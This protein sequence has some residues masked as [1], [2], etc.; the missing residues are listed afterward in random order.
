MAQKNMCHGKQH[1][2]S[3]DRDNA[4]SNRDFALRLTIRFYAQCGTPSILLSMGV[5]GCLRD[6]EQLGLGLETHR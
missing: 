2:K 1:V 4:Q 6:T 5:D 3:R